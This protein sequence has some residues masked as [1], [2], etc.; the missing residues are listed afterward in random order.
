MGAQDSILEEPSQSSHGLPDQ[1]LNDY[2]DTAR[3]KDACEFSD[4][5]LLIAKVV[6]GQS[7]KIL[8]KKN[9]PEVPRLLRQRV[10]D[11]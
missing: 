7:R 5:F 6:Y 4:S 11:S 2:K 8:S 3:P 1:H 10:F 9:R